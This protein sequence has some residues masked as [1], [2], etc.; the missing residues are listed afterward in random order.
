MTLRRLTAEDWVLF[1]DIRSEMLAENPSAFGSTLADWQAKPEAEK[2]G[3]IDKMR[4]FGLLEDGRCLSVAAYYRL[5][6]RRAGHRGVVIS[7]YSRPEARRQGHVARLLTA[8]EED[9]RAQGLLQL[10]L[11]TPTWNTAALTAY[12]RAGYHQTGVVPRAMRSDTGFDDDVQM[13]KALDG[14][15]LRHGVA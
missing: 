14:A 5:P 6:G 4:V 8:I 12:R 13:I 2:R 9:A 11:E 1:D 3:W 10:E 7:V 15:P